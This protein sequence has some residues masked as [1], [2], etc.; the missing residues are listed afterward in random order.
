ML[1]TTQGLEYSERATTNEDIAA[2]DRKKVVKHLKLN[3]LTMTKPELHQ[4]AY[5]NLDSE[6]D[7]MTQ[8][9]CG[10][11]LRDTFRDVESLHGT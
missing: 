10:M 6:E 1:S 9:S 7:E 5:Q 2:T 3:S 8:M 11:N 4:K